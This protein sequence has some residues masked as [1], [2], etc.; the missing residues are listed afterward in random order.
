MRSKSVTTAA[1]VTLV[2]LLA[3]CTAQEKHVLHE[4]ENLPGIT[5]DVGEQGVDDCHPDNPNTVLKEY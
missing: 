4:L 5:C 1:A 2:L 3:G